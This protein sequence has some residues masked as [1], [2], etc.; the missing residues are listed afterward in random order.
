MEAAA[1]AAE[2]QGFLAYG[3]RLTSGEGGFFFFPIRHHSP[4]C[5]LHLAAALGEIRP[6]A[7]VLEMPADFAPLLPLLSHPDIRL[8]IAIVSVADGEHASD[9]R[10]PVGYWPF[11]ATS[12]EWA[13]L[14]LAG[15]FGSAVILAD[16][17]SGARLAAARAEKKGETGEDGEEAPRQGEPRQD[18]TAPALLTD[19]GQL[20]YSDYAEGLVKRLGVRDF[21]EAWDRLFESRAA[22]K[23]WRGFF[24]DVG[25]HCALSRLAT[26]AE[27]IAAD[28]TLARE[29]CMRAAMAKAE[30]L[31]G[32][33]PIAVITGGF[34]TP[35]MIDPRADEAKVQPEARPGIQTKSYLIR[36]THDHLDRINGYGAGM[37]SP[38]WYER[39]Q[40]RV[41][42]GHDDPFTEAATDVVLDLTQRLRRDRPNFTPPLPSLAATVAQAQALADLRGLQGP[43]RAEILDAARSCLMKG[44]DPH[45]GSPLMEALLAE[46]TGEGIGE[47]P[48]GAG[49]PPL[50]EAVRRRA[51][52]LGFRIEDGTERNRLLDI[53]RKP[54]HLAASRFLHVMTLLGTGFGRCLRGPDWAGGVATDVLFEEWTYRWSPAVESRLVAL[55]I[56]GDTVERA[57][58]AVLARR[59]QALGEEGQAKNAH[60]AIRLLM[61]AAQ[62]GLARSC[63]A[64]I[65]AIGPAVATD[66][67]FG[68]VAVCLSM[69]DN[70]QRG[71][72]ALGFAGM[73]G[74]DELRLIA[75]RRAID[76]LPDL[77]TARDEDVPRYVDALA[78]LNEIAEAGAQAGEGEQPLDLDLL[79][80][81]VAALIDADLAP[82][83][84][85]AVAAIGHMSGRLSAGALA[86]RVIGP[87]Q[88]SVGETPARVE[89]LA[90]LLAVQP[91]LLKRT[92]ALLERLD[93]VLAG[94]DEADFIEVLPA[95][96]LAFTALAPDETDALAAVIAQAKGTDLD[97]APR[98]SGGLTEAEMLAN[99]R[100][101]A[102]FAE[103][104]RADGLGS[105]L[106]ERAP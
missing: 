39:L 17:E 51:R 87:L 30:A 82:R 52:A 59:V 37:P 75:Y 102:S 72:K 38:R 62:A 34:H 64:L 78:T 9:E 94:F 54:R 13:A 16:R 99:A 70:L 86:T 44:E 27:E 61:I 20:A 6:R 21:N 73:A 43:G 36:Y 106:E 103:L 80:E 14:R 58:D 49:V 24:R 32:D 55:S 93:L 3:Q 5:A 11:S 67:D 105:W 23:D 46:L 47:V 33:G 7:I 71:R 81:G 8:P 50:V 74:P 79:D 2:R 29:A 65:A 97:L 45:S 41:A 28:D 89:A 31:S 85:G 98:F 56:D 48:S 84:A 77:E 1:A 26:P 19:E 10:L 25:I 96:R 101:N 92:P 4:A 88:F 90:G 53:H 104:M 18:E 100:L 40:Q 69:L 12:P 22:E 60:A 76:L 15:E 83:A 68:R 63:G 42:D 95:L 66:P 35:V 91:A 57:A